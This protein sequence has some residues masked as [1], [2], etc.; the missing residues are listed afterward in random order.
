MMQPCNIL[1][2]CDQKYYDDWGVNLL[3][4]IQYFNPWASLHVHI[5]NPADIEEL[6]YV[7]YTYESRQFESD[8][9]RVGYL[10]CCRFLAVA[11]KFQDTDLVMT[12]DADS[13]CQKSVSQQYF[14]ET[15]S[16]ITVLR[17]HKDKRWLAGMMTYGTRDFKKTYAEKI[18]AL[19]IEQFAPFHDQTVLADMSNKFIFH[20]QDPENQW[21]RYGKSAH[22][23]IFMTLKGNEKHSEK[24]LSV[25]RDVLNKIQG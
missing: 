2:G 6:D 23:G 14:I 20:E 25:Y 7:N 19:P 17:H 5:V 11:D 10:Q 3:K 18:R 13:L 8:S 4:S 22:R 21:M 12:V 24:Y 15:A 1:I 16:K 9:Q